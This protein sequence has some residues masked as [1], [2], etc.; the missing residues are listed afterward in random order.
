[1]ILQAW[2]QIKSLTSKTFIGPIT[3]TSL[4]DRHELERRLAVDG[5]MEY[6][7]VPW[8]NHRSQG[9]EEFRDM[10]INLA[11]WF[12]HIL[13]G[14]GHE[15]SWDYNALV[16]E[17]LRSKPDSAVLVLTTPEVTLRREGS[18]QIRREPLLHSLPSLSR[19]RGRNHLDEDLIYYSFSKDQATE[20][21]AVFEFSSERSTPCTC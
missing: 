1:M 19:K 3:V 13:A 5:M 14:N 20:V 11:L 15:S 21:R 9:V 17:E 12:I 16:A 8:D 6:V 2:S 10:T 4:K 18:S 7:S